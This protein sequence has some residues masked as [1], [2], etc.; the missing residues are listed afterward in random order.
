[1]TRPSSDVLDS[2]FGPEIIRRLKYAPATDSLRYRLYVVTRTQP[3]EGRVPWLSAQRRAWS[4]FLCAAES[5]GLLAEPHGKD[6]RARLADVDDD[7]FRAAM[8]ECHAAWYLHSKLGLAVTP[9]PRGQGE[10]ELEFLAKLPGGDVH[11]EV[12]SPL[13]VP[14]VDGVVHPVDDSDILDRCLSDASKQ[15]KKSTRNL[16][17]L[18]GRLTLGTI[19]MR[20][21]FLKAFYAS[22]KWVIDRRTGET[23][24]VF[25]PTG[26]FLRVWPNE[27]GP[28]HTRIGGVL[29]VQETIR[30]TEPASPP[31]YRVDSDALMMHNP[32]AMS[33][34]PEEVWG[35]CPQFVLRGDSLE[36]T[37]GHSL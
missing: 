3:R 22:K 11:I 20:G 1:M 14:V 35:D 12:K 37:D 10:S 33:P 25:E 32:N 8:A 18:V 9:R 2:I 4:T 26:R 7:Q 30:S 13:R 19:E 36:W 15:L 24:T 17:M 16:V 29:F 21:F 5:C 28:R 34:L 27:P 23:R 31:E 6:L